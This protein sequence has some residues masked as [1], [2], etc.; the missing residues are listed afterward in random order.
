MYANFV[1]SNGSEI[2]Q[3][4]KLRIVPVTGTIR[5]LPIG[6]AAVEPY[7]GGGIGVYNW[8]YSE[9]GNFVDF[10]D[11]SV[12]FNTYKD[13]GNAF[14]GVILG[15]VR[16]PVGNAF[17]IGAEIKYQKAEGDIDVAQSGLLGS[18]IDLGGW[19]TSFTMHVRF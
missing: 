18:K 8:H 2:A 16:A 14:G 15:G 1:N 7:V 9:V 17:A 4:L 6:H 13:H 11:N 19:T 5:F 12:F 3:E 10:S